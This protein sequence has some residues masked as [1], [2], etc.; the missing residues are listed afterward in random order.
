MKIPTVRFVFDRRNTAGKN[1]KG[2]VEM[3]ITYEKQRKFIATGVTCYPHNWKGDNK[4]NI[5]VSGTGADV[6]I[7]TILLTLYQKAYR[8]VSQQVESGQ[9][10]ISAIP[11]LLKAQNVDMTFL[12]Y[13]MQRMEK[14]T[15][16]E[17]THKSHVSFY[18]KLSEF[19]KI[20]FFTDISEKSIRDFDEWLHSYK[21]T[22][23]D[24]YGNDVVKTY[25]QAT[26]GS[27]HKN[28]KAFINDAMVDGYVKDNPYSTKRIKIDKGG[29]RI[30]KFLTQE[31]IDR[32]EAAN[33]PTRSLE[34]A[35]DLFLV[36]IFTG[37][38][39]ADL[40]VYDFTQCKD[41][42][43]YA[44]F[45][46]FRQKTGVLFTFVLTPKAKRVLER[47]NYRLPKLPNQK[48]NTKLKMV[49]DAAVIDKSIS[50]HDGRRSCGFMLLNAGVPISVVSRVLGHSS[51]R[52]TEMAYARVLDDTIANEIKKHVK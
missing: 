44:I 47:Y 46:G 6:E 31:E 3:V 35:R 29:T 11:T 34:E 14:K 19:G 17:Y 18:N 30:D 8:I 38:A 42:K 51:I 40:M 10:D 26:I 24:R 1:G 7:N 45:S 33:M 41:A 52:Q 48:Y 21:W 15:V 4:R 20:K 28:L 49:A 16:A 32:L 27:F 5:Y 43:D 9:V 23:K 39:Y 22:E 13:I 12:E 50:S 25:S 37:L 36:Q 2:Y